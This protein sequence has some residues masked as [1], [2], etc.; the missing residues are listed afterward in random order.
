MRWVGGSLPPPL[1]G[2]TKGEAPAAKFLPQKKEP[3]KRGSFVIYNYREIRVC[4]ILRLLQLGP[5]QLRAPPRLL[6]LLPSLLT[7]QDRSAIRR[8]PNHL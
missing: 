8:R 5:L 4:S 6:G 2:P 7:C 3:R 1:A